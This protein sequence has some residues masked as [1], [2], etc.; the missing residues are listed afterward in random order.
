MISGS[1][2]QRNAR[3]QNRD[4]LLPKN[5]RTKEHL[6]DLRD[7]TKDKKKRRSPRAALPL[8]PPSLKTRKKKTA[9]RTT[10]AM[11]MRLPLPSPRRVA[12]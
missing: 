1:T 11:E 12:T 10:R 4:L 6:L 8:L 5:G 2:P 7:P 3:S 9:I